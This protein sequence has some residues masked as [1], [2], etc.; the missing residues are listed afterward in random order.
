MQ[1]VE[2]EPA[3]GELRRGRGEAPAAAQIHAPA[4]TRPG[5]EGHGDA[6]RQ[7]EGSS[8]EAERLRKRR[9]KRS[10]RSA[11]KHRNAE[12]AAKEAP[13]DGAKD[14]S[15]EPQQDRHDAGEGRAGNEVIGIHETHREGGL[16]AVVMSWRLRGWAWR[17]K[18]KSQT[19]FHDSVVG[20][21]PVAVLRPCSRRPAAAPDTPPPPTG[22]DRRVAGFGQRRSG[23]AGTE[24]RSRS[25]R[26]GRIMDGRDARPKNPQGVACQYRTL[27]AAKL[28]RFTPEARAPRIRA[29]GAKQADNGT[30]PEWDK[31][32]AGRSID[33]GNGL[34]AE[35]PRRRCRARRGP[36]LDFEHAWR[37]ALRKPSRHPGPISHRLSGA[38]NDSHRGKLKGPT[39]QTGRAAG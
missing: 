16:A 21:R 27:R 6:P 2:R 24:R 15:Q 29:D 9:R 38:G 23:S 18:K 8:K 28:W 37:R 7:P 31:R 4:P 33:T 22:R 36:T 5:S 12:E 17:K 39:K 34:T 20:R 14:E 10:L 19:G 25:R 1:T 30:G 11:K 26:G 13:T 35:D 3:D 32:F